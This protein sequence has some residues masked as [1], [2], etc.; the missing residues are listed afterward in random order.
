VTTASVALGLARFA[1][2]VR[3]FCRDVETVPHALETARARLRDRERLLL[4]SLARTVFGRPQSPY[5]RLLRAAGCEP[6]DVE[7]LVRAEGVEGALETLRRAGVYVS[8]EEF[9]GLVPAVRGSQRFPFTPRDFDNPLLTPHLSVTSGGSRARPTRIL[10]DLAYLAE[11]SPHWA[12]WFEAHGWMDRPQLYVTAFY[13]GIVNRYLRN[14]RIGK[15]YDRWF[16]TAR[17]GSPA[18]GLGTAWIHWTARRAAGLPAPSTVDLERLEPVVATLADGAERGAP[19]CVHTTATTAARLSAI[20][21]RLG[22][23]LADVAFCLGG[24]PLTD[25]RRQSIEAAGARGVPAYGSSEGALVGVQ[26]PRPADTDDVHVLTDLFTVLPER[27]LVH[28]EP[29]DGLLVT[30]L[31]R[32]GPKVL[33]NA[34]IGDVGHLERRPCECLLGRLGYDTHLAR[35]RSF[36]KLTGD[37]ATFLASDLYA[38]LEDVLPRRFGGV[39]GDYQLR[40]RQDAHGVSRYDLL[41]SPDVGPVVEG[42]LVQAFFEGLERQRPAY[43]FM[44]DQWRRGGLV[45]VRRERPRVKA[46]G[47]I[48]PVDTLAATDSSAP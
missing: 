16:V 5:S 13:P 39:T 17:G 3:R 14:V 1:L 26:C 30:G 21:T 29:V 9:K 25:A 8:F 12:L 46:R 45:A 6:G 23:S 34:D 11:L 35:I 18:Y 48:P 24:E 43:G 20:A 10:I 28:G 33:L 7:R 4:E 15:P 36:Q 44:V 38:L 42:E 47:K 32:A 31:L 40:E 27:R 41:V 19:A 2:G 37:G 22:R